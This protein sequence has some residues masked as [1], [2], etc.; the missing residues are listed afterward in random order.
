MNKQG[1]EVKLHSFLNLELDGGRW[2]GSCSGCNSRPPVTNISQLVPKQHTIKVYR[3][4]RGEA[5][6]IPYSG[7]NWR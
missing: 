3:G 5:S 7:T 6:H 1:V 4:C 2:L